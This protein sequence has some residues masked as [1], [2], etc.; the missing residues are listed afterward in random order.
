MKIQSIILGLIITVFSS[1]NIQA[2]VRDCCCSTCACPRGPQGIQGPPGIVGPQGIQGPPGLQGNLGPQGPD[3]IQG[4]TGPCRLPTHAFAN[5]FSVQN[6]LELMPGATALMEGANAYT[7]G[8]DI[9]Q[10]GITGAV[11]INLP[12]IYEISW[13]A[14]GQ[15]S[16][17]YP[18]PVPAWS[19]IMTLDDVIIPG[20]GSS[21][22]LS[23]PDN[24]ISK[25][26]EK[27]IITI[28][29][30]QTLRLINNTI[31]NIDLQSTPKGTTLP[32]ASLSLSIILLT[33][34]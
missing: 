21:D 15:L 29:S 31:S 1:F 26:G 24:I 2:Q 30:G 20:S 22:F 19:M 7:D 32:V 8:M 9:S 17:P 34:L 10:A 16:P 13:K 3:G 25:I 14:T 18:S 12:G 28:A 33:S 11:T 27:V 4:P 6:Q 5:V 23:S